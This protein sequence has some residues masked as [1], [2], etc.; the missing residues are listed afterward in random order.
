MRNRLYLGPKLQK[1]PKRF[2]ANKFFN[3]SLASCGILRE[4]LVSVEESWRNLGGIFGES[5]GILRKFDGNL[6]G[7]LGESW[8]GKEGD[9]GS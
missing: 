6:R 2:D 5:L 4:P 3:R 8:D 1:F 7:N 9:I